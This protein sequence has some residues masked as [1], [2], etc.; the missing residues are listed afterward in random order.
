[1]SNTA[2]ALTIEDDDTPSPTVA[3]ALP[4]RRAPCEEVIL[5]SGRAVRLKVVTTAEY[6]G[7]KERAAATAGDPAK[8][9]DPRNTRFSASLDRE[10]LAL[11]VTAYTDPIDWP[12]LLAAQQQQQ[13]KAWAASVEAL[14]EADRPPFVFAPD[15]KALLAAVPA[16]TWQA[17]TPLALSTPGKH[18]LT[19]VFDS[20]ADWEVL[21]RVAGSLLMPS[22]DLAGIVGKVQRVTR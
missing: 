1:M 16:T 5:P 3:E 4:T 12:R 11:A 15:V 14:P 20:V 19:E 10:L 22:A 21:T 18:S 6:L 7:A 2:P 8:R 17:T 9:P 13:A